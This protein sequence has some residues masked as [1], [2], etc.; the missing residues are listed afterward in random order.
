MRP[1]NVKKLISL[2]RKCYEP[3]SVFYSLVFCSWSYP[4]NHVPILM[5]SQIGSHKKENELKIL[6]NTK[7]SYK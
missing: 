6:I 1:K 2:W 3:A 7:G 5:T 4:I